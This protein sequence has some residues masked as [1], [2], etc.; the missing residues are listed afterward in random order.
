LELSDKEASMTVLWTAISVAV[1]AGG[2]VL[3]LYV[4]VRWFGAAHRL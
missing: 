1:V 4:L 3:A 2:L